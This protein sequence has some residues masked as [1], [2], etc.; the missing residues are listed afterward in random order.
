[1]LRALEIWEDRGTHTNRLQRPMTA[2]EFDFAEGSAIQID[3]RH[4]VDLGMVMICI[5][6]NCTDL[7]CTA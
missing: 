2:P 6:S 7:N 4:F 1:M 5:R 3:T